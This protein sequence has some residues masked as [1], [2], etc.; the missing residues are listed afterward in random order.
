MTDQPN[1]K[2]V[3]TWVSTHVDLDVAETLHRTAYETGRSKRN[4]VEEAIRLTDRTNWHPL[5]AQ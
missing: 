4:L 1:P 3:P 5:P 2:K